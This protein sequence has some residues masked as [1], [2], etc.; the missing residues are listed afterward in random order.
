M[1]IPLAAFS[2]VDNTIEIVDWSQDTGLGWPNGSGLTHTFSNYQGSGVDV[3]MTFSA[4]DWDSNTGCCD[5]APNIYTTDTDLANSSGDYD[6]TCYSGYE[7]ALRW[8]SNNDSNCDSGNRTATVCFSAPVYINEMELASISSD[9]DCGTGGDQ[10]ESVTVTADSAGTDVAPDGSGGGTHDCS[11]ILAGSPTISTGTTTTI[12]G[13]ASQCSGQYNWAELAYTSNAIDCVTMNFTVSNGS[14]FGSI[15]LNVLQITPA[16]TASCSVAIDNVT[17]SAC[18]AGTNTY[19]VDVEVSYANVTGDIDVNG[20]TFTPDGTSPDTFTLT[21]LTAD[22]STGNNVTVSS[23]DDTG[24]EDNTGSYDAPASCD[25]PAS[26]IDASITKT[27][28]V[29]Q[30][31]VGST[32]TFTLTVT[33]NGDP[34][35]GASVTDLL[36]SGVSYDSDDGAGAY[37]SGTGVWT[38]GDMATSDVA[39]LN[40][41]VI[42]DEEGVHTNTATLSVNETETDVTNNADAAC[43]SVPVVLCDDGSESIDATAPNGYTTYQW[44]IDLGDG[45]GYTAIDAVDGGD[46]QTLNITAA[47]SYLFTVDDG[48]LG[49]CGSQLCCPIIVALEACNVCPPS[50]CIP[51]TITKTN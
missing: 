10:S 48:E 40:I 44:Y 41:S 27:A 14:S 26:S 42:V 46:Q 21:G 20:T 29:A 32:V 47:G 19:S 23:V 3:T 5:D 35:T 34:V 11:S 30:T 24:C 50:N 18:D 2:Q 43:V 4:C 8:T 12:T 49:N 28:D 15:T 45:N 9:I 1:F 38:I 36:P 39:T 6:D 13:T 17:P 7:G 16:T 22:G 51:V 37:D 25:T 33:N 31:T